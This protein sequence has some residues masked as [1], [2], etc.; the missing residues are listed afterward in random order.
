MKTRTIATAALAAAALSIT[1]TT[2]L[3]ADEIAKANGKAEYGIVGALEGK[4]V[5]VLE[6]KDGKDLDGDER[7]RLPRGFAL[8]FVGDK[9]TVKRELEPAS[10]GRRGHGDGVIDVANAASE[11]TV[12][13]VHGNNEPS[14]YRR[15]H[16]VGPGTL[17]VS[18][19][20]DNDGAKFVVWEGKL[21]FAKESDG[22]THCQGSNGFL[23]IYSTQSEQLAKGAPD[24]VG[25]LVLGGTGGDQIADEASV[26]VGGAHSDRGGVFDVNTRAETIGGFSIANGTLRY[27][28]GGAVGSTGTLTVESEVPVKGT[29]KNTI[30]ITD[31]GKWLP[32]DYVLLK[33]SEEFASADAFLASFALKGIDNGKLVLGAEKRSLILR[34]SAK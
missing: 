25:V 34:V 17:V 7:L 31:G 26:I 20:S 21:V 30:E 2:G 4:E 10:N 5:G 15:T 9:T 19:S 23:E 27:A 12:L 16:K 11:L 22:G 1:G 33:A 13:S 14:V 24:R 18:G 3:Q 32:G 8:R 28:F 29:G 6:F